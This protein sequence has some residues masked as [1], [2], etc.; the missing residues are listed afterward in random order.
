MASYGGNY[1]DSFMKKPKP[2]NEYGDDQDPYGDSDFD[3]FADPTAAAVPPVPDPTHNTDPVA[4]TEQTPAPPTK[5]VVDNSAWDTD[6]YSRPGYTAENYGE[7]PSGWDPAKWKNTN[8]QTPKYV[9]G[10]IIQSAGDMKVP[11]NR[12]KAIK[13][14]QDAYPGTTFNGKDTVDIPGVGKV[15]IFGGA[16]A[17]IYSTAWQPLSGVGVGSFMG[18]GSGSGYPALP[19]SATPETTA[20]KY[21]SLLRQFML[22][23]Q[24]NK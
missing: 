13:M 21:N 1:I 20:A 9:V 14:I 3:P 10:R 18:N 22:R 15:D 17:G 23:M 8:H 2:Y 5:P 16:G 12:A 4:T 24:G 19:K 11:E 6:G 7:A